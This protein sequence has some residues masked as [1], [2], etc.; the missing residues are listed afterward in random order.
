[1]PWPILGVPDATLTIALTA[2]PM[3]KELCSLALDTQS[4]LA[5]FRACHTSSWAERVAIF[6]PKRGGRVRSL[7]GQLERLALEGAAWILRYRD[8]VW[9]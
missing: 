9:K 1:M 4:T 3:A 5:V 2:T 6:G 8:K 7:V